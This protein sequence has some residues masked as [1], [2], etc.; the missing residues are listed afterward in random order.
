[1]RTYSHRKS[2][3]HWLSGVLLLITLAVATACTAPEETS[4]T[5]PSAPASSATSAAQADP[6]TEWAESV[7]SAA[8]DVRSSLDAIGGSLELD[9]TASSSAL[10]QVKST[11]KAQTAAARTSVT[12][13]GTAIEAIPVDADGAAEVKSSL[14]AARSSLD[15]AVQAV[16][17]G[18]ADAT[19]ATNARDFVTA[20]AQT[21]QAV[22]AATLAAEASLT[23]AQ[24]AATAAAASSSPHSTPLRRASCQPRHRRDRG[25]LV[26]DQHTDR[27]QGVHDTDRCV[28]DARQGMGADRRHRRGR[29]ALMTSLPGSAH[30]P[31]WA[32]PA[33]AVEI[34]VIWA[35]ASG[36]RYLSFTWRRQTDPSRGQSPRSAGTRNTHQ[37]VNSWMEQDQSAPRHRTDLL[38]ARGGGQAT[39]SGRRA[40]ERQAVPHP[41]RRRTVLGSAA[42]SVLHRARAWRQRGRSRVPT[43]VD[44]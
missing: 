25:A 7:C 29:S 4:T 6:N 11:L 34:L 42:G 3:R 30:P 18:V 21:A 14:D 28:P 23:S 39:T 24:N 26:A 31:L 1:M 13:L 37:A 17:D 41:D 19:G 44:P 27:R 36:S 33:I 15:D 16:S 32:T 9:P 8:R 40:G 35:P 20:A 10:D 2:C 5:T 38:H 12:E 22:K 43:Q